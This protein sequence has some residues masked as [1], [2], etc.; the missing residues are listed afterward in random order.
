MAN[1]G[2]TVAF[3]FIYSHVGDNE[4]V[5]ALADEANLLA[6]DEVPIRY[7]NFKSASAK[8][9]TDT[10]RVSLMETERTKSL[11][12]EYAKPAGLTRPVEVL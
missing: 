4:H 6:Q 9:V 2:I 1:R 12:R 8:V 10:W 11:G 7:D 3:H 5:D